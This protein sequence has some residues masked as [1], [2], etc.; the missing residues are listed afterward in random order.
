MSG[1]FHLMMVSRISGLTVLTAAAHLVHFTSTIAT[2]YPIRLG[3][4]IK[5][6]QPGTGTPHRSPSLRA[7]STV[8]SPQ[9]SS[10]ARIGGDAA[11]PSANSSLRPPESGLRQ[12]MS[13]NSM[14]EAFNEGVKRDSSLARFLAGKKGD[15]DAKRGDADAESG[16]GVSLGGGK[17][18]ERD[19]Y[20]DWTVV[21]LGPG[22]LGAGVADGS[23]D[24]SRHLGLVLC[25]KTD[26]QIMRVDAQKLRIL[27]TV[28]NDDPKAGQIQD[29]FILPGDR[30]LA[31]SEVH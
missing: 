15:A 29:A 27:T 2:S 24:V 22:G 6:T 3:S 18:L 28:A 14:K 13:F 21:K 7:S 11:H 1:S 8:A 20:R 10:S 9:T 16:E 19:G 23:M 5:S 25:R 17:E 30:L 4:P 31:C 26:D 12:N